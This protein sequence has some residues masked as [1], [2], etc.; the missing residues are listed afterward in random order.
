MKGKGKGKGGIGK[1][2][3][4]GKGKGTGCFILWI[5]E[6]LERRMPAKQARRHCRRETA[7]RRR[8]ERLELGLERRR[9][10]ERGLVRVRLE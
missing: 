7:R 1:G 8:L 4:K 3:L 9:M 10:V 2:K 5:A 6:P